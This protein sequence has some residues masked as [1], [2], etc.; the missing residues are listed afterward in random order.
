[1]QQLTAEEVDSKVIC[2]LTPSSLPGKKVKA[3]VLE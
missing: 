1:M 3:A 2:C